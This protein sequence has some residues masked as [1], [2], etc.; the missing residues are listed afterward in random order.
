MEPRRTDPPKW[1]FGLIL[2]V[3]VLNALLVTVVSALTIALLSGVGTEDVVVIRGVGVKQQ[4]PSIRSWL[5]NPLEVGKAAALLCPITAVS[6]GS[7]GL[8]AGLAGG[9]LIYRR[10]RRIRSTKRLLFESA[11]VGF[12]LGCL[13]PVFDVLMNRALGILHGGSGA[14]VVIA[15]AVGILCALLCALVFRKRFTA[16][17]WLGSPG[18]SLARGESNMDGLHS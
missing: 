15:P 9:A 16:R 12:I 1:P 18:S 11:I 13:F 4:A 17:N 8:L 10:R 5:P 14:S 7:F 3:G 6:C 2:R